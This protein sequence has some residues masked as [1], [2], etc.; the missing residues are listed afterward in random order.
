MG[1]R[2][3]ATC[4]LIFENCIVPKENLLG[5]V[6]KASRIAMKK[7]STADVWESLHRPWVLPSG[8]MDETGEVCKRT[9]TIRTVHRTVSEYSIPIGRFADQDSGVARLLVRKS[10][11]EKDRKQPFILLTL[12]RLNCLQPKQRWR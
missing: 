4:E 1:I 11:L 3:S 10:S 5:K 7:H 8:A 12:H 9:E 6:G 2:G